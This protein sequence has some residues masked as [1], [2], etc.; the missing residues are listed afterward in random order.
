MAESALALTDHLD[1]FAKLDPKIAVLATFIREHALTPIRRLLV[2]GCGSGVEAAVLAHAL[3][4]EVVGIDITTKFDA[5]AAAAVDLR[6]GDATALEFD[7]ASFDVVFSYHVLEHVP[8]YQKAIAEIHRV[9]VPSGTAC[10]GTPNRHRLIGYLGSREATLYQKVL[11]NLWDWKAMLLGRFRNELGAHAGFTSDELGAALGTAFGKTKEISQ[12][13]Y[14]CVYYKH[15]A[16][17]AWLGRSGL[18]RFLFPAVYFI[19]TK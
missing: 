7:D 11:W 1:A 16:A 8:Q 19:A 14:D 12:A 17:V 13:Y 5:R 15:A 10:V 2:V 18:G 6:R 4:C 9:L 3:R